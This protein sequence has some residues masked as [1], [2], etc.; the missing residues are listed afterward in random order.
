MRKTETEI[1]KF[2]FLTDKRHLL[3]CINNKFDAD[4]NTFRIC[5][6]THDWNPNKN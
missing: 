2:T 3:G 6:I 1:L 5:E 4:E